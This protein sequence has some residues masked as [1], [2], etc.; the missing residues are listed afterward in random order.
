MGKWA[1]FEWATFSFLFH[2]QALGLGLAWMLDQAGFNTAAAKYAAGVK[3]G[4]WRTKYVTVGDPD[5]EQEAQ[6][7]LFAALSKSCGAVIKNMRLIMLEEVEATDA[8]SRAIVDIEQKPATCLWA[9]LTRKFLG[10]EPAIIAAATT[11]LVEQ[12]SNFNGD[13]TNWNEHFQ[14]IEIKTA[15]LMQRGTITVETLL[16]CLIVCGFVKCGDHWDML[17]TVLQQEKAPTLAVLR[18][19]AAEHCVFR[20]GIPAGVTAHQARPSGPAKSKKPPNM[21]PTVPPCSNQKCRMDNHC[22]NDCRRLGGAKHKD[23]AKPSSAAPPAPPGACFRCGQMGHQAHSCP[24]PQANAAWMNQQ[25]MQQQQMQQ[26]QQQHFQPTTW[27]PSFAPHVWQAGPFGPQPMGAHPCNPAAGLFA[28]PPVASAATMEQQH[29]QMMN[30]A[31]QQ[32]GLQGDGE[33]QFVYGN[34]NSYNYYSCVSPS[35]SAVDAGSSSL[36]ARIA[37]RGCPRVHHTSYATLGR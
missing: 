1:T 22:G 8:G 14:E 18:S 2:M 30:A 27:A 33:Q 21:D 11:S 37:R 13:A 28:G 25:Q 15:E 5:A 19:R 23:T 31:M 12:C 32:H 26:Q 6:E 20:K 9:A 34:K 4:K 29:A 16:F 7:R 36:R 35:A 10:G 3:A 17:A 24:N